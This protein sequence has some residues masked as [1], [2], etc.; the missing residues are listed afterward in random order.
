MFDLDATR[1]LA[2]LLAKS[3]DYKIV[4]DEGW[5]YVF[6]SDTNFDT[7]MANRHHNRWDQ[8]AILFIDDEGHARKNKYGAS[9]EK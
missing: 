6:P 7:L 8:L 2:K 9:V 1:D 4:K 5:I 3:E